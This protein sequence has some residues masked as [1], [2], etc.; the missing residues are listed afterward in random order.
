MLK[1]EKIIG[2]LYFHKDWPPKPSEIDH[3]ILNATKR[4]GFIPKNCL[5]RKEMPEITLGKHKIDVILISKGCPKKCLWIG[6]NM[7]EYAKGIGFQ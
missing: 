7:D 4:L 6:A 1:K 3:D 2:F 5:I